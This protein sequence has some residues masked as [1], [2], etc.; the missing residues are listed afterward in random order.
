VTHDR[1]SHNTYLTL[2]AEMGLVAFFFYVF[3]V[4]WWLVSSI[5]AWR[6]L[7]KDGFWSWPLLLMLW[8]TVFHIFITSNLMDVIRFHI[9][10]TTLWWMVLGFIANMIYPYIQLGDIGAPSWVRQSSIHV[11]S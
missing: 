8:L 7:P 4:G 1:T 5:K 10:G 9:F 11:E 6:R 2:M 3:P